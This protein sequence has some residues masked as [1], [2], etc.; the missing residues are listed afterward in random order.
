MKINVK[1]KLIEMIKEKS[2][3]YKILE[4]KAIQ[5]IKSKYPD[6]PDEQ[7]ERYHIDLIKKN[8]DGVEKIFLNTVQEVILEQFPEEVD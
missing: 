7:L 2:P 3:K 5:Y 8:V 1:E 6:Y 4:K